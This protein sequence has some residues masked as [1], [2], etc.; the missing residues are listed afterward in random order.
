[1]KV[2][3]SS[4]GPELQS[5]VDPR[6]G[7]CKFLIFAD[8]DSSE[9]EALPNPNTDAAGGAGIRTAQQVVER[10]AGAVI[11]GNI[12]PNAMEV[13][14]SSHCTVYT[15]FSGT[16]ESALRLFK[17]GKL[18]PSSGPTV[19]ERVGPGDASSGMMPGS[20][21]APADSGR[22]IFGGPLRGGRGHRYGGGRRTGRW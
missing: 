1:M 9:W 21:G 12:G 20:A 11:T 2:A 7:R 14:S 6:F 10:G 22:G 13:L 5:S 3:I 16:V 17:E 18:A 19:S 15:G 4:T 8:T